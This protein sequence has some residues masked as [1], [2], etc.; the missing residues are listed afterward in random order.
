LDTGFLALAG[1]RD[2]HVTNAHI[3]IFQTVTAGAI[4]LAILGACGLPPPQRRAFVPRRDIVIRTLTGTWT[5]A[6]V[7]RDRSILLT[8]TLRQS[9]GAVSGTL[10]VDGRRLAGD[11]AFPGYI[12]RNGRF[13]L[14]F[15]SDDRAIVVRARI[16]PR[17]ER[18]YA[19]VRGGGIDAP[20]ISF[21]RR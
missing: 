2:R 6:V 17:A 14:T 13:A 10:D 18:L 9:G 11:P 5:G 7:S 4:V 21:W 3:R 16:D 20:S 12:D 19:S 15:G 8:M 1:G